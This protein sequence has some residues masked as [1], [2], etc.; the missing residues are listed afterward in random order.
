MTVEDTFNVLLTYVRRVTLKPCFTIW[1]AMG[2][3]GVT[4]TCHVMVQFSA[5][6]GFANGDKQ[7]DSVGEADV[8]TESAPAWHFCFTPV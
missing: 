3:K 1:S 8:C 6:Q 7:A 5:L 4:T 2:G